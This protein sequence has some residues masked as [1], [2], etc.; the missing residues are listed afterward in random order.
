M[1][2]SAIEI[3]KIKGIIL[4]LILNCGGLKINYKKNRNKRLIQNENPLKQWQNEML[5][6]IKRMENYCHIL[7]VEQT[8]PH[9]RNV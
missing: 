7:E 8:F 9:E 6:H 4:I 1:Q 3:Q 2:S 5:K